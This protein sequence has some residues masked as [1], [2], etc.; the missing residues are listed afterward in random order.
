MTP[1]GGWPRFIGSHAQ[2]DFPKIILTYNHP[3]LHCNNVTYL[4]HLTLPVPTPITYTG[5]TAEWDVAQEDRQQEQWDH[6][7]K[8]WILVERE[9]PTRRPHTSTRSFHARQISQRTTSPPQEG[10]LPRCSQD[11]G[12]AR[13]Q[14]DERFSPAD[15]LFQ[16][17]FSRKIFREKERDVA[18]S[19]ACSAIS[20]R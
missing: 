11:Q 16:K 8:T 17:I 14:P 5:Q 3:M 15:T 4:P 19:R 18:Q 10:I 6:L 9:L 20:E 7:S 13:L 1:T 12:R 2:I